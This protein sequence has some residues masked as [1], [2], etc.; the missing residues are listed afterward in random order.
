M[1][2]TC[3]TSMPEWS[4][5]PFSEHQTIMDIELDNVKWMCESSKDIVKFI[6]FEQYSLIRIQS[7]QRTYVE[8][9]S[10][11]FRGGFEDVC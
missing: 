2:I 3:L 8:R 1:R 9:Y 7:V 10:A 11:Y 5:S 6:Y 4:L